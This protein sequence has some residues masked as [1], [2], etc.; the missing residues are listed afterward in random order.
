M[1]RAGAETLLMRVLRAM[2]RRR[3]EFTFLVRDRR[4]GQYESELKSL[5]C[6]VI[7]C[8]TSHKRLPAY[9]T[10]LVSLIKEAG[11]FD[12]VHSHMHYFDGIVLS[13]AAL[14]GVKVRVSHSHNTNDAYRDC[15]GGAAYRMLMTGAIRAAATH[16]VGVSEAAYSALFGERC[17]HTRQSRI[18]LNALDA[19]PFLEAESERKRTRAAL[20]TREGEAAIVH[21]GRFVEQKNHAFAVKVFSE[22]LR[23]HPNSTLIL[24]G[25]GPLQDSI[26]RTVS[27]AGL[28]DRVRILGRRSDIDRILG[29]ADA[30]LFPSLF[31]GLGIVVIEAQLA[32]LPCIVSERVPQEAD[33]GLGLFRSRPL[34]YAPE[35]WAE[36]ICAALQ[37]PRIP[38]ADRLRAL[39]IRGYNISVAIGDWMELY[40]A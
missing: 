40:A 9:F 38:V 16:K 14:A 5:G 33:L 18:M 15:P 7:R 21:V 6:K 31:E 1:D 35:A 17:S 24:A 12:A 3:V 27:V 28:Q 2:D 10:E 11:P 13:A 34:V 39:N 23:V 8:R 26:A 20:G 29:A 4:A 32:G 19:T 30:L 22:L 37:A 36:E 25:S